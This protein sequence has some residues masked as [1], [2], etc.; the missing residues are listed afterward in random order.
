ME[1]KDKKTSVAATAANS[2]LGETSIATKPVR[3]STKD[4]I[5]TRRRN[6][7]IDFLRI[8]ACYLVHY[9]DS[10]HPC[11]LVVEDQSGSGPSLTEGNGEH[12][13]PTGTRPRFT[14]D[15]PVPRQCPKKIQRRGNIETSIV[16]AHPK[17]VRNELDFATL[18]S[19]R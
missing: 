8:T 16:Y 14:D 9:H 5:L 10:S 12:Q 3:R 1:K 2:I 7:L 19:P 4:Q 17:G 6:R 13:V 18:L 15:L 11:D